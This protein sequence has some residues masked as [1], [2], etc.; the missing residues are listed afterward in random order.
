MVYPSSPGWKEPT[1]SKDAARAIKDRAKSVRQRVLAFLTNRYPASFTADEIAASLG[2][3]ILT[4]RPR[5]SELLSRGLI[6][7]TEER[8]KNASGMSA[9]CWRA[10]GGAK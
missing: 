1:S 7:P 4:T 2:E 10:K 3:S 8:R 9:H 6:E 5:I